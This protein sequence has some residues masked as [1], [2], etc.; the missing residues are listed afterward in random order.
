VETL[1]KDM[2]HGARLLARQPGFTAVA[3]LS[4]GLGVG[5]NT[6]I[7]S[8]VNAVLFKP[9]AV[10]DADRL[11]E[12]YSG[13]EGYEHLTSSYP[14]YQDLR[15]SADAFSGM[16][17]HAYVSALLTRGG[18]AESILGEIVT[19]SYFDVLGVRTAR[20]RTFLPEEDRT[21][22]THPVVVLSHGAWQRRLGGDPEIVGKTLKLSG[23]DYTIVG[24]A[25]A[26]FTGTMPG[27]EPEFWVPTMMVE[28]LSVNGIQT[29]TG[30]STGRTRFERRGSRWLFVKGR[31]APGRTIEEARAQVETVVAR[32]AMEY[33]DTN[34]KVKAS[35]FPAQDVRIHPMVDGVLSPAAALLLGAAGLVLLIA[36]ANVANMLL[37]RATARRKE[38]AVRL[39]LGAGRWRLMRQLLTE[40]LVLAVLGGMAGVVMAFW[41]ARLL[42]TLVP[43]LPV[44]LSFV[45]DLDLRVLVFALA[46]SLA[47]S[48]L[49]GL[50]PA[51]RASRPDLVPA[52]KDAVTGPE[53]LRRRV[54]FRNVLVVGQLAVSLVLLIAGVLLLRGLGRASQ[55][56]PGFDP[57]RLVSLSFNL[58]MNGYSPE[59]ATAFQRRLV[60]HLEA[61]PGIDSVTLVSRPPLGSDLN[62]ESVKIVG[63][64]QPDDEDTAIDATLVEPGYFG[65]VGLTL[66]EGRDFTAADDEDAPRVA[67]VNEA[68]ARRYWP[69]RSPI[70][71][72]IHTDGFD[73]DP[74]VIVGLVRDY[75]VRSLGET[76][77]PYLHFP[78]RQEP[79]RNVTVLARSA[80][81]AA[82]AV[83]PLRRAILELEPEVAFSEEGTV[84][85]LVRMTLVPTRVGASLVGA[86]GVLALLLAAVGLYGVIA[87]TV[88]QRTRE[89][90]VRAALG[91]DR[92]DLVKLVVGQGMKLAVVGV[93]LGVLA[94]AAVTRVLSVLLYGISALDPLAFGGAAAVLL[95][96]AL[97]ANLVPA[98]RAARVDPMGAL[99]HE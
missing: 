79:S 43:A 70:G 76:P 15:E 12:I 46:A 54:S 68:M 16:A 63:H 39:A 74:H 92:R 31:L 42:S 34:D 58:K 50:A 89:L 62:L 7:F 9:S 11:V 20:G 80:G 24:V 41:A 94:A 38:I 65:T 30:T 53:P 88:S 29:T 22:G 35:L 27:L 90:G 40:S 71:E 86:F 59:Q 73:G 61:Q 99:R 33:P 66:L 69:G 23:L 6:T 77:R 67:I 97:L 82:L 28:Q 81:P 52:L 37:S 72:Q 44:P 75:K 96:V 87:Y 64:H 25:P 18:R 56:D 2:R 14:D 10:E 91:A 57:D 83:A 26:E 48:L 95:A 17:A 47:T 93:A 78:W 60:P 98:L 3:I 13:R 84:S 19:A 21:P 45:F 85:D 55:I 32:L 1:W 36:C 49:F 4:L 5:V 51:F 8:V